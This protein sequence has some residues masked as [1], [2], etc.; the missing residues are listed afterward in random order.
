MCRIEGP[1][2]TSVARS[3][4]D[5]STRLLVNSETI[6][7]RVRSLRK[8]LAPSAHKEQQPVRCAHATAHS[9]SSMLLTVSN[10]GR[11]LVSNRENREPKP[12]RIALAVYVES[13]AELHSPIMVHMH[14]GQK[15]FC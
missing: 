14:Q 15:K 2:S 3:R 5:S 11:Y 8:S 4:R 7:A 12:Y 10:L 9:P 13:G 6:F 1:F